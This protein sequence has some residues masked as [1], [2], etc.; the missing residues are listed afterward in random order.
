[1]TKRR[2]GA[3]RPLM[4]T[5]SIAFFVSTGIPV[6]LA[7]LIYG[8]GIHRCAV[9]GRP[10]S[11]LRQISFGGGLSLLFVTTQWP[12]A[13][14]AHELFYVHQIGIMAARIAAPMLII[15]AR[16]AG[17]LVAGMPRL[18]RDRMLR[19]GLSAEAVRFAWR[20]LAH[21]VA[22]MA[23]YVTS[24]YLW[25]LP[26]AQAAA[27]SHVAV[28]LMMHLSLLLTGLLFWGCVLGRRPAPHGT[29]HGA[30]LMMIWIAILTQIVLGAYI[31]VKTTVL[32][33]AYTAGEQAMM[34]APIIDESRGGFF[35][36]I[37]SGLLSLLAL[38]VVIDM[39]GRHETRMDEKRTRWS[40]SN[41]AIL[42]YPSTGRAL[43]AMAEGKNRRLA[44]G[45]AAFVL[46][47]FAA[48]WGIVVGAH[49][50]NR[51]ENIRQY[52]LSR[53]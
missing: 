41:S 15:L 44:I 10:V 40:P 16:P 26:A 36:W 17:A 37:P 50:I 28:G 52:I 3:Y 49:R 9:T 45:M 29:T 27:L 51:R 48:V 23:L 20:V 7:A 6:L 2:S 13:D 18:L 12:F 35:I 42:L 8:R 53:S 4:A 43:I 34:V 11:I 1:L 14:W 21:P 47:V 25:E 22:I 38:I 46:L 5:A 33:A 30:R 39:W 32:Y 24:L 31:T 19:P